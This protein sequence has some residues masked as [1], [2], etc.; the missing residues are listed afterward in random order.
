MTAKM[1]INMIEMYCK[2]VKEQFEPINQTLAVHNMALHDMC[3][4][5]AKKELGI[6]HKMT[7]MAQLSLELKE[8][9]SELDSFTKQIR[10]N[11]SWKTKIELLTEEKMKV[12]QNGFETKVEKTMNDMIFKI[13]ISGLDGETKKVFEDLSGVIASLNKEIKKLPPP[14]KKLKLIKASK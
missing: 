9:E 4:K 10:H 8:L 5:E 3:E 2:M 14:T 11:N 6:Y 7:R 13:R 1:G 12:L